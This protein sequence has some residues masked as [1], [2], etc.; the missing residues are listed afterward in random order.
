MTGPTHAR[1]RKA[2]RALSVLAFAAAL[3]SGSSFGSLAE[4]SFEACEQQFAPKI[5]GA[6]ILDE[7]LRDRNLDFCL[8]MSSLASLK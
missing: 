6:H 1:V 5:N 2:G 7:L 8:L 3:T 4:L